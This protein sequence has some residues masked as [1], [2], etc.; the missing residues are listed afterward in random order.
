MKQI[1]WCANDSKCCSLVKES[2]K[3]I[4]SLI[5]S[6]SV[7]CR[8]RLSRPIVG[9]RF[10]VHKD[11]SLAFC[12]AFHASLKSIAVLQVAAQYFLKGAHA[13]E[14]LEETGSCQ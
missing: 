12:S 3:L 5:Q 10:G 11:V 1:F 2:D 4:D 6:V 7:D 8:F 14:C 13:K 9:K